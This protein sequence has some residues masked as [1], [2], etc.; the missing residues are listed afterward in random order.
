MST[1]DYYEILNISTDADEQQIK[2]SYRKLALK[3]HPDK[4]SSPD[5]VEKF[6]DISEAYEILSDPEKR[7]VYD[8]RGETSLHGDDDFLFNGFQFHR[9][10]DVFADFF[11][12]MNGFGGFNDNIFSSFMMPPPPPPPMQSPF[13]PFGNNGFNQS[14]MSHSMMH[15]SPF[16]SHDFMAQ[17]QQQQQFPSMMRQHSQQQQQSFSSSTSSSNRGN[18]YLK[19]VTTSTRS[20]NGVVE[21][22]KITKITDENGTNVIE[23]YS[24]GTTK[25]NGIEQSPATMSIENN[26]VRSR[27]NEIMLTDSS[28]KL[29]IERDDVQDV[30]QNNREQEDFNELKQRMIQEMEQERLRRDQ[31][32]LQRRNE[33]YMQQQQ[34]HQQQQQQMYYYQRRQQ[35]QQQQQMFAAAA[36][37]ASMGNFPYH[38][39]TVDEDDLDFQNIYFSSTTAG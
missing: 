15:N 16:G 39:Y 38:P 28:E 20:I 33:L 35:Q 36:A 19:S 17:Q 8:N 26:N 12:H 21:T 5:A 13:I 10:E 29:Q 34:Y 23:E 24:N 4:N 7:R 37:A 22:V 32:E 18:N 31:W 27:K 14:F 6:K 2:K 30:N 3:Y 9:P 11:N 1:I 25:I